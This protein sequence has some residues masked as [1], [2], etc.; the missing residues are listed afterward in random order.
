MKAHALCVPDA[1]GPTPPAKKVKDLFNPH[2]QT[3][4]VQIHACVLMPQLN[5]YPQRLSMSPSVPADH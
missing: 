4:I 2:A 3:R 5:C 1:Y